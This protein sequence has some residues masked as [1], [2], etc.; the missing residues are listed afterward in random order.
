MEAER[1]EKLRDC[2]NCKYMFVDELPEM[3]CD[4]K[5]KEG[6]FQ[7]CEKGNE[8]EYWEERKW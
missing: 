3:C 2:S 4:H 8:Y 5:D 7:V 1:I 6:K